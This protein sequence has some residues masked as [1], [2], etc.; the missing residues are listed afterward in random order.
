MDDLFTVKDVS[1]IFG[2]NESKIR[3]WAQTGFI[4]PSVQRGTR[5]YYTF[6]DLIAVKTAKELLDSGMTLQKV[7]KNLDALRDVLPQIDQPLSKLRVRSDGDRIVVV[8]DE[9][10]FEAET[11]QTVME[12]RT[13]QLRDEVTRM[14]S[15]GRAVADTAPPEAPAVRGSLS[16]YQW[17]QA[18]LECDQADETVAAA[19]ENYRRAL[20]Q[21]PEMAAA[22]T[23]LGNICYRTGRVNDA[24]VHYERALNVDPDQPEARFNLANI[25]EEEGKT[26]QAIAEYRRVV[27]AHPDFPD[28][29]FNLALALER[30]GSRVQ[31]SRHFSRYLELDMDKDSVWAKMAESHLKRLSS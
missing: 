10:A 29:H 17:F 19:E 1:R 11:H 12:F 6:S 23:N 28:A 26:E 31:S 25:Y 8:A 15:Q 20:E 14:L 21:D 24:R 30:V 18:G 2:M 13:V 9:V 27:T 4:N 5:R 22:H 3:Y 7:R 16:A